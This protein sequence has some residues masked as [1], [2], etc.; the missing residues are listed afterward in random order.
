MSALTERLHIKPQARRVYELLQQEDESLSGPY[1]SAESLTDTACDYIS[2]SS[3]SQTFYWLHYMD[4]HHPYLPPERYREHI[5][6]CPT[7][8]TYIDDLHDKADDGAVAF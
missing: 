5:E 3:A 4:T 1:T 6:D 2:D 8:K 7:D